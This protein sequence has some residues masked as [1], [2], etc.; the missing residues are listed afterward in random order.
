MSAP[1]DDDDDVGQCELLTD[2]QITAAGE[3][4]LRER[5]REVKAHYT[6][7]YGEY[8]S[9]RAGRRSADLLA[10]QATQRAGETDAAIERLKVENTTLRAA[11]AGY[12]GGTG[13]N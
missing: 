8:L 6:A 13:K 2:D 4:E 9:E 7:L 12:V 1:I 10:A 3:D 11:L 5:L